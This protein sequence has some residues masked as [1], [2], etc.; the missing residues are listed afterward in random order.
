MPI[1]NSSRPSDSSG[2]LIYLY[3]VFTSPGRPF[4]ASGDWVIESKPGDYVN[5]AQ[6]YMEA[7]HSLTSEGIAAKYKR[8]YSGWSSE[9][10]EVVD[11]LPD[12]DD[13]CDS[14][15]V[16]NAQPYQ[17][18]V[19]AWRTLD[20]A[21]EFART[22]NSGLIAKIGP[23]KASQI[24]PDED[25]IAAPHC[26][27]IDRFLPTLTICDPD[28]ALC[29]D[30]YDLLRVVQGRMRTSPFGDEIAEITPDFAAGL[31]FFYY[32]DETPEYVG[33]TMYEWL[34]SEFSNMEVLDDYLS[35]QTHGLEQT[36][37]L[38]N[39][40]RNYMVI[41]KLVLDFI[42]LPENQDLLAEYMQLLVLNPDVACAMSVPSEAPIVEVF[43]PLG[44]RREPSKG[45]FI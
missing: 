13:M 14:I 33:D 12:L 25:L 6:K 9:W 21:L 27:E 22:I 19:Y 26:M 2:E 43:R 35:I 39:W 28:D 4:D 10:D 41:G 17:N 38:F 31:E 29:E 20:Q 7:L 44:L 45:K 16:I 37:G 5:N 36:N 1:Q 11:S 42:Q 8:E 23:Y 3:H 32:H 24:L 34:F 30:L 15:T 40:G 18:R